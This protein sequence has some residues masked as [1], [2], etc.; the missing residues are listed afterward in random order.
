M[1]HIPAFGIRPPLPSRVGRLFPPCTA[2]LE[3]Q[4]EQGLVSSESPVMG[5]SICD[6]PL[7]FQPGTIP[8]HSL[9]KSVFLRPRVKPS[10]TSFRSASG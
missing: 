3:A 8:R 6:P 10:G 2:G 5:R 9:S 1:I 7:P 4:R